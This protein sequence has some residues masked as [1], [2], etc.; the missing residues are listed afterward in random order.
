M[1]DADVVLTKDAKQL[2][3][4]LYNAYL[5]RRKKGTNKSDAASFSSSKHIHK[6]FMSRWSWDDVDA[7]CKELVRYGLFNFL[8]AD[9][10]VYSNARIT[11]KGIAYMESRHKSLFFKLANFVSKF[12]PSS[13][14]DFGSS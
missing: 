7:T 2:L 12:I 10:T 1:I 8:S 14:Q 6:Q 11:D 9:N 5:S 13:Y 3:R 4:L